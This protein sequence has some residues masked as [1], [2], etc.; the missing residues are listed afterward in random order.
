MGACGS[1]STAQKPYKRRL[2]PRSSTHLTH[3]SNTPSAPLTYHHHHHHHSISH[4]QAAAHP[5]GKQQPLAHSAFTFPFPGSA[6]CASRP[7]SKRLARQLDIYNGRTP[8]HHA[9]HLLSTTHVTQYSLPVATP[10]QAWSQGLGKHL[11][12]PP[13]ASLPAVVSSTWTRVN[14]LQS[15]KNFTC[16][17]CT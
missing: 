4:L 17:F 8:F 7:G 13:T 14:V 10:W 1:S 16:T 3:L 5:P 12:H 6:T 2:E 11:A 9:C 15:H